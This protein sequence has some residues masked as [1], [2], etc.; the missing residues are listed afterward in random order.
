MKVSWIDLYL[1]DP[2]AQPAIEA[3][4]RRMNPGFEFGMRVR[5]RFRTPLSW[6]RAKRLWQAGRFPKYGSFMAPGGKRVV[7]AAD[8]AL[9]PGDFM[10]RPLRTGSVHRHARGWGG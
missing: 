9:Y 8:E 2:P 7:N 3:R 10:G 6:R 4:V 5:G 1:L